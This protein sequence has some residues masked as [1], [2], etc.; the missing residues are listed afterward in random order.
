MNAYTRYNASDTRGFHGKEK[1]NKFEIA[2]PARPAPPPREMG[3]TVN[4]YVRIARSAS[5]N[6]IGTG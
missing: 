2:L 6:E 1:K 5:E 3:S 4:R